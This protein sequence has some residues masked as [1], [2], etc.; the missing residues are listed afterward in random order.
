[1]QIAI[2][3]GSIRKGRRSHGVALAIEKKL[4]ET[5]D[6][7]PFIIDL[8]DAA[9]ALPE[10]AAPRL[11]AADAIL[12]VSPEYHG[13]YSAAL[14]RITEELDASLFARKPIGTVGVSGGQFGGMRAGLQMQQLILALYGFP[15]PHMLLVPQVQDKVNTDGAFLDK[16]MEERTDQYL[17]KFLW[18]AEAIQARKQLEA[19]TG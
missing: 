10:N 17:Q 7:E 4:R 13:V 9:S 16:L 18:L 12:F 2:I 6:H 19:I 8:A 11:K 14:K 1:M 3:S 5:G 15:L